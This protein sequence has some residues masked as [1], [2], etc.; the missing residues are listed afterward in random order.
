LKKK[1]KKKKYLYNNIKVIKNILIFKFIIKYNKAY[2]NV[3]III[4][5]ITISV[6]KG[7]SGFGS[8]IN[9]EIE[10]NTVEM[11]NEGF[12]EPYIKL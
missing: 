7:S 5:F 12:Q 1:K 11:F 4:S 8:C 9:T 3:T 2:Y 6:S 10:V